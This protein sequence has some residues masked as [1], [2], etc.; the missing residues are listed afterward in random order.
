MNYDTNLSSFHLSKIESGYIL[1][2]G[3]TNY[4]PLALDMLS[5]KE[6]TGNITFIGKDEDVFKNIEV[7]QESPKSVISLIHVQ[8][9]YWDVFR[10]ELLSENRR[11]IEYD[12]GDCYL[13]FADADDIPSFLSRI[14]SDKSFATTVYSYLINNINSTII[15]DGKEF[16]VVPPIDMNEL[17]LPRSEEN[18]FG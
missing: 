1:R 2:F 10:F 7:Q 4:L 17:S 16:S 3:T 18:P 12:I 6:L 9:Q 15:H 14:F 8:L 13:S 5:T 11:R